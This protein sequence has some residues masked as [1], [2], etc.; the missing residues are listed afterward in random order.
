MTTKFIV[1]A[2]KNEITIS[3]TKP[4]EISDKEQDFIMDIGN[5]LTVIKALYLNKNT[6]LF[7]KFFGQLTKLAQVGLVGESPHIDLSVKALLQMKSEIVNLE[8]SKIKNK[9]LMELG[10]VTLFYFGVFLIGYFVLNYFGS[11]NIES[12]LKVASNFSLL[13]SC[14]C[15]GVWLSTTLSK[16][17]LKFEDLNSLQNNQL[18][19]H[20]KLIFT[21]LIT[22]VFGFLFYAE[23]LSL[24]V[25]NISTNEIFK[26]ES[27]AIIFGTLLGL[28]ERT[29]GLSIINKS[30]DYLK[31]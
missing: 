12:N 21:S 11:K 15:V 30:R 27:V 25:G 3:P 31:L 16:T 5:T 9:Y 19:P 13:L 4:T 22:L 20:L 8:S 14:S 29:L 7:D 23:V 28:N 10:L 24:E 18:V 1:S 26:K 6:P 2:E 17:F